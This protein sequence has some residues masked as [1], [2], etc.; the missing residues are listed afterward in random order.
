MG[1]ADTKTA[2]SVGYPRREANRVR[3]RKFVGVA[4]HTDNCSHLDFRVVK[5]RFDEPVIDKTYCVRPPVVV[6]SVHTKDI[7]NFKLCQ[8]HAVELYNSLGDILYKTDSA[9]IEKIKGFV[10]EGYRFPWENFS[11]NEVKP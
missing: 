5:D 10:K 4:G 8:E 9:M 7:P 11:Q 2:Y 6:L 3:V 1:V